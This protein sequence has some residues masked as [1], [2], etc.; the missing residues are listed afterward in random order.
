M[1]V[2]LQRI[3][4]KFGIPRLCVEYSGQYLTTIIKINVTIGYVS[5]AGFSIFPDMN[6]YEFRSV[7]RQ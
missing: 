7:K 4:E 6:K 2:M 1:R 5:T 3:V